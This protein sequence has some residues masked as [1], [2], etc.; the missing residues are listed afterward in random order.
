[1]LRR[2]GIVHSSGS[3][4]AIICLS[5]AVSC[6]SGRPDWITGVQPLTSALAASASPTITTFVFIARPVDSTGNDFLTIKLNGFTKVTTERERGS[7]SQN[8]ECRLDVPIQVSP[9]ILLA[10]RVG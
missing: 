2:V 9:R 5:R 3:A 7:I 10:K 1:M 4:S 8:R 6:G